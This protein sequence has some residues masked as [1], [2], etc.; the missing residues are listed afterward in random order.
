[1]IVGTAGHIDHGK[2]ALVR[3]LTGVDTDRLPEEKA[4]GITIDLGF[5]YRPV[6]NGDTLGF[7]DVPGHERFIHNMLAGAVGID[8]VMLVVAADDGAMPQ[9]RE[10][11]QIIDLLGVGKGVVALTKCDLA[12]P[13][14][15][16]EASVEIRN[17][18]APTSLA[19]ADIVIVS[20]VTGTG[21]AELETRLLS[22]AQTLSPH[23]AQ[24][25]F[26]MAI[27]RSFSLTGAGTVV[28]GTVFAGRVRTG[29]RLM[30][31]P[32][33]IAARVRSIHTQNAPAEE[34]SRGQRCALNIAGPDVAKDRIRRGDW[35]IDEHLHA[36]TDRLDARIRLL[37]SEER[38]LRHWTPVHLHMGAAHVSARVALLDCET[39]G[40]GAEG[41]A[42][43]VL[44]RPLGGLHGD[45]LV[46]RDQSA[47][48]T[49]GGGVVLDPWP[50]PRGRRRPER[51]AVLAALGE[52]HADAALRR[53]A[54]G[55]PGWIDLRRFAL[56]WNLAPEAAA[57][58]WRACDLVLSG[59]AGGGFGFSRARWQQLKDDTLRAL[60]AYHQKSPESPGIVQERLRQALAS[61]LPPPV[62]GALVQGFLKEK[63]VELDGAWLRLPGHA[64]RLTPADE[65]LWARIRPVMERGRFQ[66][67]R[68]RDFANELGA[69]EEE[70]RQLLRRLARMGRLVEI[71]HDHFYLRTTAAELVKIAHALAKESAGGKI[72]ASAFRDRIGTGRKVAIQILE[73][74]D[75]TGL[76]VRQGDLRKVR[77]DQLSLFAGTGA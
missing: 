38:P 12:T 11:L 37:A 55:E 51:L 59:E 21:I 76:T 17:L 15:I 52:P 42:Q 14:R 45:R 18:L 57:A 1:M 5:A 35:I 60:T 31:S 69:R 43:L 56:S 47:Q 30:L 61:R 44:D 33:G 72:T 20:A 3:A 64:V 26:R 16:A 34:G 22:A 2:T 10:H 40:P 19:G 39:L 73:F 32:S 4:R 48:R 36:P 27:D 65:R 50:L 23:D 58:L 24:G 77:E 70:V 53:L 46:F 63:A 54:A 13:E 68:V 66:P 49:M 67:P 25:R 29:D 28:T 6:P 74:F 7:V 8:Y 41:L 71:A 62:F 9:T 75:R